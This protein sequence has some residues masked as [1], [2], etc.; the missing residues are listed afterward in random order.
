MQLK[1][2]LPFAI[3]MRLYYEL[4]ALV[5]TVEVQHNIK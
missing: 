4:L 1:N 5:P 3:V 2:C